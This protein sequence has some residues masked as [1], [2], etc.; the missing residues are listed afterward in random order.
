MAF[1]FY[2]TLSLGTGADSER[3]A[4]AQM[5]QGR[6]TIGML[7][8]VRPALTAKRSDRQQPSGQFVIS[9]FNVSRV[10]TIAP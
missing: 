2:S 9:L 3:G 5:C 10:S 6:S 4:T 1:H 7:A 8:K